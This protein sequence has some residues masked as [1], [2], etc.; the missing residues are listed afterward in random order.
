MQP[1]NC[2]GKQSKTCHTPSTDPVPR[3]P[4]TPCP[5]HTCQTLTTPP[6]HNTPALLQVYVLRPLHSRLPFWP[7]PGHLAM[8]QPL[9]HGA[10]NLLHT[11]LSHVRLCHA[12]DHRG[13]GLPH[14]KHI[15]SRT[16][17]LLTTLS[18]P[19]HFPHHIYPSIPYTNSGQPAPCPELC[20][21]QGTTA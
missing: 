10:P 18:I 11:P 14:M 20:L 21:M 2:A 7:M 15:L 8:H 19:P 17:I 6:T 9:T 5:Q 13:S 12:I 1:S 4:H 16:T 3:H